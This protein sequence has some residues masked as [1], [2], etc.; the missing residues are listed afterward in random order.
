MEQKEFS[1]LIIE[2]LDGNYPEFTQTIK[3]QDDGSFD[4]SLKSESEIFS[5]WI[6]TYNS[7]ITIGIEDPKGECNIHTH[8]A[9]YELDDLKSC[10]EELTTYIENIKADKLI[11]YQD[12]SEKYDWI[13]SSKFENL[14]GNKKISWKITP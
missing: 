8:I 9:C 5:I 11:L 6:A 7:E 14:N 2:F 4:C 1:K 3:Y 13:D 12:E 10:L